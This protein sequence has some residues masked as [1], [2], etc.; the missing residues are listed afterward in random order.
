M[1]WVMH[2]CVF[3]LTH[4]PLYT[5]QHQLKLDRPLGS[6]CLKWCCVVGE[7]SPVCYLECSVGSLTS[8]R[9]KAVNNLYLASQLYY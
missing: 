4:H 6:E 8:A 9:V 3:I 7:Y 2:R 1:S 5:S